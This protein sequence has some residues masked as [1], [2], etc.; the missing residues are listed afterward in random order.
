MDI[1][2]SFYDF[3]ACLGKMQDDDDRD[4]VSFSKDVEFGDFRLFH[5]KASYYYYEYL[6]NGTNEFFL[7]KAMKYEEKSLQFRLNAIKSETPCPNNLN[8]FLPY[9]STY[10]KA[11]KEYVPIYMIY[12][13]LGELY[14]CLHD[15]IRADDCYK[16]YHFYSNGIKSDF[17]DEFVY[18][19][20]F[21][22]F[23]QYSI[24]DL[25]ANRITLSHVSEMNDPFDSLFVSWFKTLPRAQERKYVHTPFLAKSYMYYRIRSFAATSKLCKSDS[26]FRNILMWSHYADGHKGICICY[27]LSRKL[28]DYTDENKLIKNSLCK[29]SYVKRA[30]YLLKN[31]I[32]PKDAF[33]T[34]SS[35]W[36]YEKE[37]RLISYNPT[38]ES[39]HSFIELDENSSV[40]C[41]YLGDRFP[42]EHINT[43]KNIV[44][45]EIPI[46][47]M[48]S[49]PQNVYL[50]LPNSLN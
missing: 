7:K 18:V 29:I 10:S 27:R 4:V 11:E 28:Y 31:Y 8:L 46:I 42:K 5:Y 50:L 9:G 37:V 3:L 2:K 48:E 17:Q 15:Y 24:S 13:F 21:R 40:N 47:Q 38:T 6:N 49:E 32:N 26:I 33:L 41:I 1:P 30:P 20:S 35:D 19:Y 45:N 25:I 23:N 36:N 39:K 22:P 44:H 14:A 16:K 34:K 43:I 12:F